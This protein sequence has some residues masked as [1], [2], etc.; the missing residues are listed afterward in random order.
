MPSAS[1]LAR[2]IASWAEVSCEES[3]SAWA[4]GFDSSMGA[5]R[6]TGVFCPVTDWAPAPFPSGSS[7]ATA[8]T[9]LAKAITPTAKTGLTR[10][11]AP[12][13]GCGGRRFMSELSLSLS[14]G[15]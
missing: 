8:P 2:R 6:G 1:T 5:A 15:E 9:K 13:S 4:C 11:D 14:H 3:S 10:V 7:M 12:A